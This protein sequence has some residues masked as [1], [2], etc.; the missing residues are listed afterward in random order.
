MS[1]LL[2]LATVAH[3]APMCLQTE[4]WRSGLEGRAP[5]HRYMHEAPAGIGMSSAL[6][7]PPPV[8]KG[9]YGG[10]FASYRDTTNFTI[11]WEDTSIPTE[12]VD[13][14]AAAME[15]AWS[16]LIETQGWPA[17]TSSDSWYLWVFLDPTLGGT[18]YTA[19]YYTEDFPEGYPVI[20]VNPNGYADFGPDFYT[21]LCV[22]EFMHAIQFAMRESAWEVE[23]ERQAWYWEASATHAAELADPTIDGHQYTSAWYA[24]DAAVRF[25]TFNSAH[26]YGLFV[27]NAWLEEST[28]GTGGMLDVW[29]LSSNREGVL[30]DSILAEASGTDSG[31][32]WAGFA[33]AYGNR[34]LAE[35]SLYTNPTTADLALPQSG[36]ADT[37]GTRYYRARDT[38]AVQVVS[39]PVVLSGPDGVG[40]VV[41]LEAG[42]I[43]AVTSTEDGGAF[44]LDEAPDEPGDDGGGDGSDGADGGDGDEGGAGDGGDGADGAGD[45]GE[46]GEDGA[47]DSTPDD[48]VDG[49]EGTKADSGCSTSPIRALG[50]LPFLFIGMLVRRRSAR[51]SD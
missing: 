13:A 49:D 20:W 25:D 22:H 40:E 34:Q 37:L 1:L 26:E 23:D 42:D 16:S 8:G 50:G 12:V 45:G 15:L 35:S 6:H 14:T 32:L 51:S 9:V 47:T 30:W 43:L 48:D 10:H 44:T 5:A 31:D 27:F 19:E 38:V 41:H 17:P 33:G 11:N 24:E 18:G 21:S 46:D 3:A 28:L 39:G 29:E 36:T 2:A 7:P 4:V